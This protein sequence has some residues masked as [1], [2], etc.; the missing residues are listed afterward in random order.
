MVLALACSPRLPDSAE[1]AGMKLTMRV[2]AWITWTWTR[3]GDLNTPNTAATLW[4][5]SI[6]TPPTSSSD[7]VSSSAGT[8]LMAR[9]HGLMEYRAAFWRQTQ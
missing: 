3:H 6:T 8:R 2:Y 9:L 1:M 4:S 5:W 7:M